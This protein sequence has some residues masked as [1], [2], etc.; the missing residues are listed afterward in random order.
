MTISEAEKY[1]TKAVLSYMSRNPETKEEGRK[2]LLL[3]EEAYEKT[4]DIM[5]EYK[6]TLNGAQELIKYYHQ[7]YPDRSSGYASS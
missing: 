4:A 7:T 6:D 2:A 1:L 5:M 3:L